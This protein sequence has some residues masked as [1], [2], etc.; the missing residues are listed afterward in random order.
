MCVQMCEVNNCVDSDVVV[1][2]FTS[3]FSAAYTPNDVVKVDN[4]LENYSSRRVGYCRLIPITD[5]Q[6][7]TLSN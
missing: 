2:T 6:V 5:K 1:N 3:N 4:I 7:L